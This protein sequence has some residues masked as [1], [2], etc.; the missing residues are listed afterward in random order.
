MADIFRVGI[1]S[2]DR[3]EKSSFMRKERKGVKIN[4][5]FKQKIKGKKRFQIKRHFLESKSPVK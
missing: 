3:E 4:Q 2:C 1:E 5:I